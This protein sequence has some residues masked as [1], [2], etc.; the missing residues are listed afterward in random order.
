[1]SKSPKQPAI[2]R[3]EIHAAYA[4]GED[5][6]VGLV[7]GLLH[8]IGL[9][10][11]RIE[12]LEHQ[13]SK[14]SRNSSKPPVSDGFGRRTH[15]LRPKGERKSGG[16][17]GHP[18]STLEWQEEIDEVVVHPVHACEGWVASLSEV[19]VWE[20]EVRQVH[21]LEPIRL[22]VT[23]HQAA[24]KSC[25]HCQS[26][27]RG[28]FP[29]DVSSGVQYGAQIKG[30]MVYLLD[31]QLLPSHRVS[32]LLRDVF[33]CE[34]SE[35]TLYTSRERCFE[36]L[37]PVEAEI[38]AGMQTAAVGHFDETG[39]HINGKL[40]WLHVASSRGLTYYFIHPKRG[41][42]AMEAMNVLPQF[43]GVSVHDGWGSYASYDCDHALCNAHHLRE[44]RFIEERYQQPW[45]S[46]MSALLVEIK[47]QVDQAQARGEPELPLD[48][49]QSFAARYQAWVEQGLLANPPQFRRNLSSLAVVPNNPQPK[50][51]STDFI[52]IK[53]KFLPSCPISAFRLTTIKLNATS[54]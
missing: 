42:V 6:V 8:Q 3:E 23:E 11:Q 34:L 53:P 28:K 46:Q 49:R 9:L 25:P 50:T 41:K 35:G 39:L 4:Q 18:G 36:Q 45:A 14:D 16:Q 27:N 47:R 12:A 5:A 26:L 21:D 24:V 13:Q 48:I 1:M 32:Q 7:A 17:E 30:L 15:S 19:E 51:C 40:W 38:F 20:W 44:L 2:S 31:Y 29:V 22:A 10:E 54:A 33:G 52:F 37:A 43:Q